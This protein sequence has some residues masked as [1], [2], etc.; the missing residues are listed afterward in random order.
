MNSGQPCIPAETLIMVTLL[1]IGIPTAGSPSQGRI[2]AL[3]SDIMQ[4][5]QRCVALL[6][7]S[8]PTTRRVAQ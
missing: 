8:R 5:A 4:Q 7:P 2:H 1:A 3:S 6:S